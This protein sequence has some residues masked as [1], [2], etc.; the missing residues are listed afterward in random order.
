[1]SI[2][3]RQMP[4]TEPR[5]WAGQESEPFINGYSLRSISEKCIYP[6]D[7]P[8]VNAQAME[9]QQQLFMVY[10]IKG[11]VEGHCNDICLATSIER[12]REIL[13]KFCE[14]GLAAKLTTKPMLIVIQKVMAV[15]ISHNVGRDDKI[16]IAIYAC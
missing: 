14:L 13:H 2:K 10:L 1:M 11:L 15:K 16:Y 12:V 3:N 8:T 9:L 5:D 7:C 4:R 6:S